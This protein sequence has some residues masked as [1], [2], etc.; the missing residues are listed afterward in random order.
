MHKYGAY[1]GRH[2][3]KKPPYITH[4]KAFIKIFKLIYGKHLQL[5]FYTFRYQGPVG[6]WANSIQNS[7]SI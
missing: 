2:A 7:N 5:G 6:P 3:E 1:S 4:I